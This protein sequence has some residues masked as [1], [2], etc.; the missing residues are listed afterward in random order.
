MFFDVHQICSCLVVFL[1]HPLPFPLISIRF[2]SVCACFGCFCLVVFAVFG[3][4]L[5]GHPLPFLLI[6]IRFARFWQERTKRQG[7]IRQ[8]KEKTPK[9]RTPKAD[10]SEPAPGPN[11]RLLPES[12]KRQS[13]IRSL[14]APSAEAAPRFAFWPGPGPNCL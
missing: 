14:P 11:G 4:V 3:K 8:A 12:T 5:R 13:S 7:S 6:S 9:K 10:R 2:A 1:R